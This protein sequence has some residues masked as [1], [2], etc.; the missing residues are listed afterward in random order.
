MNKRKS[1]ILNTAQS[2]VSSINDKFDTDIKIPN[3]QD[4]GKLQGNLSSK[5][6]D[7][8]K[9][10]FTTPQIVF[11]V[12]ELDKDKLEQCFNYV[13]KKFGSKY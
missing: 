4:F 6:I 1:G 12:Q 5:V 7:G 11:N 9:T 13:N 3:I 8:T 2:L 10:I